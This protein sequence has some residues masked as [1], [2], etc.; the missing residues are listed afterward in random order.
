MSTANDLRSRQDQALELVASGLDY[1]SAVV[2]AFGPDVDPATALAAAIARIER[3]RQTHIEWRDYWRSI[4]GHGECA[5]CKATA[6]IA[7]DLDRQVRV[8]AEYD[9]VLAVLRTMPERIWDEAVSAVA[10][11]DPKAIHNPYRSE[12]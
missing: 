3:S 9:N 8:I 7:G 1:E 5:D 4:P 12:S 2:A 10:G 6:E 11:V